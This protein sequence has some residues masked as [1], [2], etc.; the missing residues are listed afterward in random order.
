MITHYSRVAIALLSIFLPFWLKRFILTRVLGYQIDSSAKIGMSLL[1]C[2]KVVMGPRTTIGHFN[3]IRGLAL[4]S[5]D[6][7]SEIGN[8]NNISGFDGESR[9]FKHQS[10][11]QSQLILGF[12]SSITSRHLIDC[13]NTVSIGN[14]T[15]IAGHRS[16]FLTHS[17]DFR[18]NRQHS[19]PIAVGDYCFVATECTLLGGARLPSHSLLAAKALLKSDVKEEWFVYGGVPARKLDAIDSDWAYFTRTNGHVD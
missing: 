12:H 8:L 2:R 5:L 6:A 14:F 7:D 11:R 17:I 1:L 16:E 10:D 9:Y 18:A 3:V 4:L 15:T 19:E 13:A